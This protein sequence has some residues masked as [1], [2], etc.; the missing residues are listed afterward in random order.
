MAKICRDKNCNK[1]NR[2]AAKFCTKCGGTEFSLAPGTL[3]DNGAYQIQSELGR[4]GF[5]AVYLANDARLNRPWVVKQLLIP[6]QATPQEINDLQRTFQREADSLS[7]L[8]TPGNP[9]I[10]EI[11]TYFSDANGHYLVMKYIEGETLEDRLRREGG[12]M[13]WKDAVRW[14]I[15]IADALAYM[16]SRQPIPILH[17]DIKPA[18]V[19]IDTQQWVWLVDFGLSRAQ[20]QVG[21]AVSMTQPLGTPGYTPPEQYKR[22]GALPVSDVYAL[23]AMLYHLVTGDNP[24]NHPMAFPLLDL[25]PAQMR[26]I[27]VKALEK[28]A[29]KRPSAAYLKRQLEQLIHSQS[30]ASL[31]FIWQ[32]GTTSYTPEQLAQIA[33]TKWDEAKHH[34]YGDHQFKT[35]FKNNYNN[36]LAKKVEAICQQY[37]DPDEGLE[38][39]LQLPDL[40]AALAPPTFSLNRVA[41]QFNLAPNQQ[42]TDYLKIKH[43]GRGCLVLNLQLRASWITIDQM[44]LKL[45]PGESAIVT[46]SVQARDILL[47]ISTRTDV[48]LDSPGKKEKITIQAHISIW[49]T[50][51]YRYAPLA[52]WM[53]LGSLSGAVALALLTALLI[54]I[55]ALP[56][57]L[58]III[59]ALAGGIWLANDGSNQA[60][61][62]AI[63]ALLGGGLGYVIFAVI[64]RALANWLGSP[65][66]ATQWGAGLGMLVGIVYYYTQQPA[67]WSQHGWLAIG[68]SLALAGSIIVIRISQ[69]SWYYYPIADEQ[70]KARQWVQARHS[71][72]AIYERD[73]A[74]R[75]VYEQMLNSAYNAGQQCVTQENWECAQEEF[76]FLLQYEPDYKDASDLYVTA[77]VEPLYQEGRQ[78]LEAAVWTEA[79]AI[80][81]NILLI[82]PTYK[83]TDV[84]LTTA[85]AEPLYRAGL[86]YLDAARWTEA[87]IAFQDVADI[88]PAYKEVQQK[89]IEARAEPFYLEGLNYLRQ[90]QWKAAETAFTVV[91]HLDPGYKDAGVRLVEAQLERHYRAGQAYLDAEEWAAAAAEFNQVVAIDPK[92]KDTADLLVMAQVEADYQAGMAYLEAGEWGEAVASFDKVAAIEPDYK[93]VADL[94]QQALS[95]WKEGLYDLAMQY[96]AAGDWTEAAAAFAQTR[97]LDPHYL[98]VAERL[99][100]PPL[101][102]AVQAFY[103]ARWQAEDVTLRHT[104]HGHERT[105]TTVAFS[106]MDT[107]LATAD[108]SGQIILWDGAT[109]AEQRRL[110]R[111][112][113]GVTT[114]TF[115]QACS[116]DMAACDL[117]LVI[118]DET[119]KVWTWDVAAAQV[120]YIL[121][122]HE[123][124]IT[125]VAFQ[126]QEKLLATGDESGKVYTWYA[127]TGEYKYPIDV[128]AHTVWSLSYTTQNVLAAA[129]GDGGIRF[130]RSGQGLTSLIAHERPVH[131]VQY[132]P[133]GDMFVSATSDGYIWLWQ[134][135]PDFLA[136]P[137]NAHFEYDE[138]THLESAQLN[139]LV[140]SPQGNLL[141]LATNAGV[142]VWSL[143]SSRKTN[144]SLTNESASAAAFSPHGWLLALGQ[145]DGSVQ[146][147]AA[148]T[149]P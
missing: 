104:L 75:D 126:P 106:P 69:P 109:G 107:L 51:Y 31:P 108:V 27:I 131:Q 79:E 58:L 62:F 115:I 98:D 1:S 41:F 29:A 74:Y 114:L 81:S 70:F 83:D 66:L 64:I 132:A 128:A 40:N 2:D 38:A 110:P 88:D 23:V 138:L 121:T 96:S 124:K 97:T 140:F 144:W 32:D 49:R 116:V 147:W 92:Y 90:Q 45:L 19:L 12:K 36:L 103:E 60:G 141:V 48:L 34:L 18:N 149:G 65:L 6:A 71:Y 95:Q 101:H 24:A 13:D 84:L 123:T 91:V 57:W 111:Q 67:R 11:V 117:L 50:L 112:S 113:A 87:E 25:L 93:A 33:D 17:R 105:I 15:A 52:D 47:P 16:H 99:T 26:P 100:Q 125:A 55:A 148:D 44:R 85:R 37:Q 68:L 7:S 89:L 56:T 134:V 76:G 94:R 86:A 82:T 72:Q 9:H 135:P 129:A 10:P 54:W 119:G 35:W 28:D 39:F 46:L 21:G 77:H 22:G 5:G 133:A 59:P 142:N 118:G 137:A 4:G 139:T 30:Q 8:N 146:I 43:Q 102:E 130:F 42:K 80:L 73:P 120:R 145:G 53:A 63:G 143:R 122:R 136:A 20:P 61:G 127:L 14:T 78:Y 3:L